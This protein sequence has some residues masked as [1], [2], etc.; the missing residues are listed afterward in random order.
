MRPLELE[1]VDM[2]WLKAADL[3][4]LKA[5][6]R[7]GQDVLAAVNALLVTPEGRKIANEMMNDPDYVPVSQ[8]QP[9]PEEAAQIAADEAE[10]AAQAAAAAASTQQANELAAAAAVQPTADPAIAA[11]KNAAEDAAAAAIGATIY[12][13]A[14]GDVVKIV[15]DYQVRNDEGRPVGRPTHFEARTFVEILGKVIAAHVNAVTYG[16]R[17]KHNRLKQST[18]SLESTERSQAAEL[19]LAESRRLAAEAMEAKD[20]AKMQEAINKAATAER[21]AIAA[22]NAAKAHGKVVAETWINDHAEDFLPIQANVNLMGDYMKTNNLPMSY[23]NLEK[24]FNGVKDR[25]SPVP[26]QPAQETVAVSTNSAPAATPATTTDPASIA[27]AQ[28]EARV[29]E[30]EA[31]SAAAPP[32]PATAQEATPV[33]ANQP[34]ATRRPGVNGG[35]QPGQLSAQRPSESS[36]VQQ[37]PAETRSQLL[38]AIA[39]MGSAEFRKKLRDV[40]YTKQ[41]DAAGIPYR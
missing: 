33:V 14:S 5:A 13:D 31:K 8:R 18:A 15:V 26:A 4:A 39:K 17:V 40:N 28:M 32:A 22:D 1:Q 9:D 20:P 7:S 41:L 27:L 21:E 34:I 3:N 35:L 23:D 12:R 30:L 6:M 11:A 2:N 29:K 37:T 24:A 25:L 10:A 38:R 19:A 36:K 16:E